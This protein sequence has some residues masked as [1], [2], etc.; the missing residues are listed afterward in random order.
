MEKIIFTKKLAYSLRE[1]GCKII[2]TI[3]NYNHP[4]LDCYVFKADE[5]FWKMFDSLVK[6]KK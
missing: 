4:E 6:T 5:H 2:K 3:P 1:R